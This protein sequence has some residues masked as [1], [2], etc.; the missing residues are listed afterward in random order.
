M[1]DSRKDLADRLL[2]RAPAKGLFKSSS[3]PPSVHPFALTVQ[4]ALDRAYLHQVARNLPPLLL[5]Q[6]LDCGLI[7]SHEALAIVALLPE[8]R[9][10]ITAFETVLPHL[11]PLAL[12]DS[13]AFARS[14]TEDSLRT[15]ALSAL[16]PILPAEREA[17]LEE[18]L[19]ACLM[20]PTD[21][22]A[23]GRILPYLTEEQSNTL[24]G[25]AFDAVESRSQEWVAWV[26]AGVA[27]YVSKE[28]LPRAVRTIESLDHLNTVKVL[29]ALG[30]AQPPEVKAEL[31]KVAMAAAAAET[32][33]LRLVSSA[34]ALLSEVDSIDR[35]QLIRLVLERCT[36]LH[37]AVHA[38]TTIQPYL[39]ENY[40][41]LTIQLLS[42]CRSEQW[43]QAV[44]LGELAAA[45]PKRRGQLLGKALAILRQITATPG[46]HLNPRPVETG[47]PTA[48][49]HQFNALFSVSRSAPPSKRVE[50]QKRALEILEDDGTCPEYFEDME[51]FNW[52]LMGELLENSLREAALRAVLSLTGREHALKALSECIRRFPLDARREALVRA[53]PIIRPLLIEQA[54]KAV[55]PLAKQIPGLMSAIIERLASQGS[56]ERAVEALGYLTPAVHP[57]DAALFLKTAL[58]ITARLRK[59]YQPFWLVS[60]ANRMCI[61]DAWAFS[62]TLTDPTAKA[63]LLVMLALRAPERFLREALV[64]LESVDEKADRA[65]LRLELLP[66]LPPGDAEQTLDQAFQLECMEFRSK[67]KD[68]VKY[69]PDSLW[70]KLSG[71][72]QFTWDIAPLVP[73]RLVPELLECAQ[74]RL[75]LGED[76]ANFIIRASPRMDKNAIEMSLKIASGFEQRQILPAALLRARVLIAIEGHHPRSTGQSLEQIAF[77]ALSNLE[78]SNQKRWVIQDLAPFWKPSGKESTHLLSL[79]PQDSDGLIAKWHLTGVLSAEAFQVIVREK[80]NSVLEHLLDQ[81]CPSVIY[82]TLAVI[83]AYLHHSFVTGPLF[84]AAWLLEGMDPDVIDHFLDR[85]PPSERGCIVAVK[86]A[87]LATGDKRIA[88]AKKAL[89]RISEMETEYSRW[90]PLGM[91]VPVLL[92]TEANWEPAIIDYV[93]SAGSSPLSYLLNDLS[94]LGPAIARFSSGTMS[95]DISRS[96]LEIGPLPL[97]RCNPDS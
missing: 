20:N 7:T 1:R 57:D 68:F 18:T 82:D 77:E 53:E 19:K 37:A 75:G 5:P 38:I 66:I 95:A 47:R 60:I 72:R 23:L 64:A 4:E 35:D 92:D 55:E 84:G 41:E 49:V 28:L 30:A 48:C 90:S 13:L 58:T 45:F 24:I 22:L 97:E 50:L 63:T 61:A 56:A 29:T 27:P 12:P 85:F 88:L 40:Y 81:R 80:G 79:L 16:L 87:E 73:Q 31:L 10:S 76:L 36:T 96:I 44:M 6:L 11:Q 94:V 83:E 9:D 42:E 59:P 71:N 78:Y 54:C 32:N 17:V 93:K 34:S 91:L 69:V 43:E 39:P 15:S 86:L 3:G 33:P 51:R 62:Q 70:K 8:G 89:Q 14:Y 2:L 74:E 25:S 21:A 67:F 46:H 52:F 65:A 26:V